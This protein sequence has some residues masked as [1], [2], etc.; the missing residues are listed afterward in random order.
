MQ[1]L[2]AHV[3]RGSGPGGFSAAALLT[4]TWRH[5]RVSRTLPSCFLSRSPYSFSLSA[6][7]SVGGGRAAGRGGVAWSFWGLCSVDCLTEV[8]TEQ[9]RDEPAEVYQRRHH[10]SLVRPG[11]PGRGLEGDMGE[12]GSHLLAAHLPLPAAG[13]GDDYN[14]EEE[15]RPGLQMV[16][17]CHQY[18]FI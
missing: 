16:R 4:D 13:G 17:N 5:R 10:Q 12:E 3:C 2:I 9:L 6:P 15:E 1:T 11:V 8:L 18:D 7:P 14:P